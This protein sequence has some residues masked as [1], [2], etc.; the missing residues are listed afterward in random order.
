M[1]ARVLRPLHRKKE[2][3][4]KP[5]Q[6][7]KNLSTTASTT[8]KPKPIIEVR[9]HILHPSTASEY[10]KHTTKTSRLRTSITPL[11]LFTLPETGGIL[12]TATHFYSYKQG[13]A[14]RDA[15]RK[16]LGQNQEWNEYLSTVRPFM[17]Q[18]KSSIFVEFP[19]ILENSTG[20]FQVPSPNSYARQ[21][22]DPIYEFRRYQLQL[23]YDTVPKF[24]KIYES[25]LP[26]KLNAD[27]TDPTTSLVTV[28]YNEI[29][30]LN[31]VIEIWRHGN[32]VA[33]M[34]QS[35]VAARNV[36]EWRNAIADIAQLALTFTNVIHKPVEFSPWN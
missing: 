1:I 8:I 23:G 17:A 6:L 31:E 28:M 15:C 34:E 19:T 27:N 32:G 10:I 29:G 33:G 5:Y 14:E 35:R 30:Q 20:L 7:I 9:E 3:L 4:T 2:F 22:I 11:R 24:I 36:M 12:S 13:L 21:G 16:E 25:G 18:Q 26:H